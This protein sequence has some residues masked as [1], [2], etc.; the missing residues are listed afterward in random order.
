[1]EKKKSAHP[2]K[3]FEIYSV[4]V[5]YSF[6]NNLL[7]ADLIEDFV[8]KLDCTDRALTVRWEGTQ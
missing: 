3:K 4:F 8:K 5:L 7:Q 2:Y 1:M 6:Q